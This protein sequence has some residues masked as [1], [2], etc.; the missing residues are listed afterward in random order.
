MEVMKKPVLQA[1]PSYVMNIYI[2]SDS[3][4]KEIERMIN[5]FWWEC[6]VDNKGIRWMAWDRLAYPKVMGG[7]KFRDFH[8]FNL[9]MVAKQGWNIMT[10]PHTLVAKIYKARWII[11]KGTDIKVTLGLE[12]KVEFGSLHRKHKERVKMFNTKIVGIAYGKYMLLQKPNTYF[13]GF[14]KI[15]YQLNDGYKI[16][17][18]QARQAAGLEDI[19]V[20]RLQCYTEARDLIL[21]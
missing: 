17:V 4:I 21:E 2:L 20:D 6:G 18:V 19:I 10:R 1:I 13:G 14:A 9:A 15:A 16:G 7:M 8:N 12:R 11:G 5:S 3:T